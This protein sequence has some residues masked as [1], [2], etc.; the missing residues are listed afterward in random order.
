[1]VKKLSPE[2]LAKLQAG[3]KGGGRESFRCV[4]CR[5]VADRKPFR[6][7]VRACFVKAGQEMPGVPPAPP[8]YTGGN[9]GRSDVEERAHRAALTD[10]QRA[11]YFKESFEELG[12]SWGEMM[13][14]AR[15]F[16]E[17]APADAEDEDNASVDEEEKPRATPVEE[18]GGVVHEV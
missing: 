6:K 2:H 10:E 11:A 12:H 15:R 4:F 18:V 9:R 7:H 16:L 5:T 1:M 8:V 14:A 17:E 3:R 13:D